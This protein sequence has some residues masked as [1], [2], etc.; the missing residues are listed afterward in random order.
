MENTRILA[1]DGLGTW[2]AGSLIRSVSHVRVGVNEK[3][4]AS[5][6]RVA[7][8]ES[9]FLVEVFLFFE[10]FLLGELE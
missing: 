2:I 4:T 9:L 5:Y 6:Q 7:E 3:L 1:V 8:M 10:V